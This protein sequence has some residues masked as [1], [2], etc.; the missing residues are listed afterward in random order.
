MRICIVLI[1]LTVFIGCREE[2]SKY[3]DPNFS[4]DDF[5]P[6]VLAIDNYSIN[7]FSFHSDKKQLLSHFGQPDKIIEQRV[8]STNNSTNRKQ[9]IEYSTYVYVNGHLSFDVFKDTVI[10]DFIDFLDTDL[11][12]SI[13]GESLSS[14]TKF[15]MM[16]KLF[17]S[18]YEWRNAGLG[19]ASWRVMDTDLKKSKLDF[20]IISEDENSNSFGSYV[21]LFFINQ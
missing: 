8:K 20:I 13:G 16:K 4:Q 12:L 21:E 3:Y 11:A 7:G 10:L 9:F 6:N 17:L 1:G 2:P 15:K 19:H 18:S 14:N 5:N